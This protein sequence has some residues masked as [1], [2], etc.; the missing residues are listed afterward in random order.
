MRQ[1]E[2]EVWA[3][4][5]GSGAVQAL[6]RCQAVHHG[7]DHT[8]LQNQHPTIHPPVEAVPLLP[9]VP[10]SAL[11]SSLSPGAGA[12]AAP[13]LYLFHSLSTELPPAAGSRSGA[14]PPSQFCRLCIAAG[15]ELVRRE[16][17][18]WAGELEMSSCRDMIRKSD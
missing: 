7:F 11:A 8:G 1:W 9:A 4:V 10:S 15:C 16:W 14:A 18:E 5:R 6:G 17:F 2:G 12:A 13:P 3:A